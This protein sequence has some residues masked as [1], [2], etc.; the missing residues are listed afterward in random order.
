M[1]SGD[2]AKRAL[3]KAGYPPAAV[4]QLYNHM[5]RARGMAAMRYAALWRR[6]HREMAI[7]EAVAMMWT[8]DTSFRHGM[9]TALALAAS[10]GWKADDCRDLASAL[11]A[12]EAKRMKAA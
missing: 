7:R 4:C 2:K 8:D 5:F 10:S 9:M 1:L 6:W 3:I 12:E 11:E